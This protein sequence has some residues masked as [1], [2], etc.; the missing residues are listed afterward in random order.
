MPPLFITVDL[1]S[2]EDD[3]SALE[4][5]DCRTTVG[6]TMA[7][8]SVEFALHDNKTFPVTH[9][10]DMEDE[11]IANTWFSRAELKAIKQASMVT[12]QKMNLGMNVEESAN[13]T[14][15]GLQ[16]LTHEGSLRRDF[17]KQ[18]V[19]AVVREQDR[20]DDRQ[21]KRLS[22]KYSRT[23]VEEA[24][25]VGQGDAFFA[26]EYLASLREELE[27]EADDMEEIPPSLCLNFCSLRR[28]WTRISCT[29]GRSGS[30]SNVILDQ[31]QE[32]IIQVV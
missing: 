17:M 29:L 27:V 26:Q 32:R 25:N 14:A 3:T 9:L 5:F 10:D 7:H 28:S 23:S 12:V 8:K 21:L 19:Q 13:E 2:D 1:D 15:R 11:E 6:E 31:P 20:K 16:H 18:R 30:D 22:L 24:V 4:T